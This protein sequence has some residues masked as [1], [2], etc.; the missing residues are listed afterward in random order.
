MDRRGL[1][2]FAAALAFLLLS[3]Q[4][5]RGA[6]AL[7]QGD[8][9]QVL[10]SFDQ[11]VT[12]TLAGRLAY[13]TPAETIPVTPLTGVAVTLYPVT[14]PI[15]ERLETLRAT[16]RESLRSHATAGQHFL[17][18][19]K[20]YRKEVEGAGFGALIRTVVTDEDGRFRFSGVPR[21]EW[22]VVSLHEVLFD[23]SRPGRVAK[24]RKLQPR[25]L[26]EGAVG[27]I[28]KGPSV[29]AGPPPKLKEMN[30]WAYR[31]Q[32]VAGEE[33]L[34]SLTERQVWITSLVKQ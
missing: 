33:V 8:L 19:F 7:A 28:S 10:V 26:P 16:V 18:I 34:L 14:P 1:C 3:Q 20:T 25:V 29:R 17:E 15:L 21:G 5:W 9:G 2:P 22:L 11:T 23:S 31:V 6:S 13:E 27:G 4:G 32:V 12:G 24:P 30:F